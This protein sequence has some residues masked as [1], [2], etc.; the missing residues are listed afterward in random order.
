MASA[1]NPNDQMDWEEFSKNLGDMANP[2]NE[3]LNA[4]TNMYSEAESLNNAFLQGRV[5][6]DEM[7]DAVANS[8]SG[9]L[10]LCGNISDVSR[11][12][13]G[14][15]EGSRRNVIATEEQVSKLYAASQILGKD[16][17][18]LVENFAQVGIE[19]SQI[20]PNLENSIKYVQ[21]IG[22][23]AKVVV[24][25]VAN[26]M[27]LMNRF[28]FSDGVQGLTKMAAQAS[29]L[30]FDMNR[31]A[32]FADKVMT[33]EKAI[34]A[35]AGFQRLGVNI[36]NLVDPFSLMND[37]INDPGALQDS[38]IKATKQFTEFDEKT[39]TFK[40]NPQGILML[41]ELGDVTG[42]SA[43]ELSKTALAAADLDRRLSK[44]NPQLNFDKPEDKEL[45]ANMATMGEGGEYIVQ[46][47]NDKTG[48]VDKIKLSEITNEELKALR[49]QQENEPKTLEDIQKSQLDILKEINSNL[50][51]NLAKLTYG[52]AGSAPVRGNVAGADRVIRAIT[53]SVDNAVPESAKIS[54]KVEDAVAEMGR[55][56]TDKESGKISMNDFTSKMGVLVNDVKETASSMGIKGI[57]TLEK[58]LKESGSKVT[59]NSGVEQLFKS[60]TSA[61]GSAVEN[62]E[63]LTGIESAVKN[64]GTSQTVGGSLNYKPISPST[65][66]YGAAASKT[67]TAKEINSKVDFGGTLTIKVD[68]PPGISAQQFKTYFESEEFKR[69]VYEYYNQKAK[70]MERR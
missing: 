53:S 67:T 42:V 11:T 44:I 29:M 9:V 2:L 68:A 58:L 59:G 37:A 46:L 45:L 49:K 3:A 25:D 1:G 14:I 5:R 64:K 61:A 60:L 70:E 52:V 48:E 65:T 43:K 36:G 20:G 6:M 39:K 40:I 56:F 63:K 12:M 47:R 31:T 15:A 30:R 7:A 57:Q 50:S 32:E 21:S 66:N 38:I 8:S 69:K 23:N 18:S 34:E 13:A 51:G 24:K 28:N 16:S 41:K 54:K 62:F 33:P 35:A 55:I 27:E 26:N 17:E 10:R 4:I 22:L 19:T